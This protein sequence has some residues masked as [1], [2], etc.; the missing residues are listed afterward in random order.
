MC[1]RAA[2]RRVEGALRGGPST[3]E[4]VSE[5]YHTL[6]GTVADVALI[7]RNLT[8]ARQELYMP[9][10][11][12]AFLFVVTA[13]GKIWYTTTTINTTAVVLLYS[14]SISTLQKKGV[15]TSNQRNTPPFDN[16][17]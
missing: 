5:L 11:A 9:A 15:P 1:N 10:K 8:Y 7:S 12:V 14:S 4:D 6:V 16:N 3:P 17:H 13:V 2:S